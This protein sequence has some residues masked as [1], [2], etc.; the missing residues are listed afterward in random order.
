MKRTWLILSGAAALGLLGW[1][2]RYTKPLDASGPQVVQAATTAE[3]KMIAAAGRVEPVSEEFKIGSELDGRLRIVPVEEGQTIRRGDLLAQLDNGDYLARVASARASVKEAE[4]ALERLKNGSR[5]EQ[6][7]EA[8]ARLREAEAVLKNA[9]AER[10]RRKG[11]LDRG[12]ISRTEFDS[13]DREYQV[14]SARVDAAKESLRLIET[15]TRPE[16]LARAEATLEY[17]RSRLEEAEAML[18]K[19]LVRSP[20][21]GVILRRKLKT[22]ESVTKGDTIVTLADISKLRVRMDVDEAD[23]ARLELGQ[24]GWV[25]APAYPD[26]KFTGKV[27]QIGKI[28]GRKNVRSDEPTERVDQKILETLLELDPGQSLPVGLR[29]DAFLAEAK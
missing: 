13:V 23:V 21:N 4:A 16:D 24:T 9:A 7:S 20:I 15:E 8:Q 3:K 12:A 18:G 26:K 2:L 25:V 17:N 5:V 27:V 28:L 29:V 19:T 11:L 1:N 22:G 10:D 6:R 14:A